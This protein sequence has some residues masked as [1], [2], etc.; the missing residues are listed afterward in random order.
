MNRRLFYICFIIFLIIILCCSSRK[1]EPYKSES[2]KILIVIICASSKNV[3]W[4]YEREIWLRY[5]QKF[6]NI[7][8][9]FTECRENFTLQENCK[10]N[11]RPG[12]FQKSVLSLARKEFDNYDYYIRA[13]LSTFYI[14]E[15]LI[16]MITKHIPINVPAYG[17]YCWSWGVSGTGIVMNKLAR[18]ILI[19]KGM[20]TEYFNNKDIPDDVLISKILTENGAERKCFKF[21]YFW[22]KDKSNEENLKNLEKD[23]IPTIRLKMNNQEE[24]YMDICNSLLKRF[25]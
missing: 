20:N 1:S 22:K 3:R 24:K 13:N 7:N 21:M 4:N 19:H 14:F 17:G 23:T 16:P 18:N 8:C 10:E 6:P 9:V 5:S 15:Y 11:Y 25:Y 2:P 12:I